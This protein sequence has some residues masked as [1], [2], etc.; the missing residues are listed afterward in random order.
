[1]AADGFCRVMHRVQGRGGNELY[2]L[3]ALLV[4]VWS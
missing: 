3:K 4:D 2:I 1:M